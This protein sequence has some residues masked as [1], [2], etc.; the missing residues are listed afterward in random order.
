MEQPGLGRLVVEDFKRGQHGRAFKR[1]LRDIYRF[2]LSEAERERLAA[3][4][5]IKRWFWILWWLLRNLLRRLSPNRRLLLVLAF[6]VY[7]IRPVWIDEKIKI[8]LDFSR[9]AFPIVLLV[10]AL[11]LKDKLL[12][13][14]EIEV[15]RQVQLSLLPKTQP[16]LPGWELSS[17]TIPAN[18]V[19]GDLIDYLDGAQGR[20]GVALGDVAGKGMGAALLCAKLQATLRALAPGAASLETLGSALNGVLERSG[21][22]N[23]YATLFYAELEPGSG[24]VRYLNAGHNPALH[25]ADGRIETLAASSLPLGMLPGTAYGRGTARLEA[26]DLVVLYSDGITEAT[27]AKGEEFGLS[28][29]QACVRDVA[30]LPADRV[31]RHVLD[32]VSRFLDHEKPHDDQSLLVLRRTGP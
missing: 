22:D 5:P 7:L 17:A 20:L 31:V 4:R 9:L 19:G 12:A 27:D 28:R 24:E 10:L 23:R 2:Y 8:D 16:T 30:G 25:V 1:D 29:L 13:R 14:D 26:N 32:E 11:E 3:M 21:L 15:A 6:L 18:D